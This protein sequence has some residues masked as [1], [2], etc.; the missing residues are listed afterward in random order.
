M[1]YESVGNV[2]IGYES[3]QREV[4]YIGLIV[5]PSLV[6]KFYDMHIKGKPFKETLVQH[7]REFLERE[8]RKHRIK[9]DLGLGFAIL[10]EDVLNVARWN[11]KDPIVIINQ[12]YG[13]KDSDLSTA[14]LLDIREVGAFC[15]WELEIVNNER[16]AW[17]TY[18]Q[19]SRS[20]KDKIT[21]LESVVEGF[22]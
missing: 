19:S 15:I 4:R 22:L 5:D 14:E 10:S 17:R 11:R 12:V 7:G 13:Y 3:K 20:E 16:N 1:T 18:L 9:S 21:Y 8:I 6:L 2:P